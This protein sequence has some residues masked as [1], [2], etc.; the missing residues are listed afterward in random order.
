MNVD[1]LEQKIK[2][3]LAHHL[4]KCYGNEAVR[5]VDDIAKMV[6][7]LR[8]MSWRQGCDFGVEHNAD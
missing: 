6:R 1:E 3:E 4:R 5:V 7:E 2:D 8:N